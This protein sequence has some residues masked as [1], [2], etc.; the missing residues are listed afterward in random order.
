LQ[1]QLNERIHAERPVHLVFQ[2]TAA[3]D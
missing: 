2:T 3:K 1:T